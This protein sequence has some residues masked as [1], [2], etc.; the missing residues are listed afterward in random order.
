[1][2][3]FA[4]RSIAYLNEKV[5]EIINSISIFF[6]ED[7]PKNIKEAFDNVMKKFSEWKNNAVLFV[8]EKVP[9][10]ANGIIDAF[11]NL[12][13]NLFDIGENAINGLWDGM[14]NT[15]YT[16]K[17]GIADFVSGITTGFTDGLDIHS[18]SRVMAEIGGYTIAGFNNGIIENIQTTMNSIHEWISNIE[19]VL[20]RMVECECYSVVCSRKMD[21]TW[22]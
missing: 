8:T 18:P 7:L 12:K 4:S 1:M 22:K 17:T 15:W 2:E 10:I 9:E 20:E 6:R 3:N 5:P 16:V 11:K 21:C 14:K 19:A 13:D